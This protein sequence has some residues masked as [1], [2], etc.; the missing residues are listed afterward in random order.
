M[1]AVNGA[2]IVTEATVRRGPRGPLGGPFM[3]PPLLSVGLPSV[4]LTG[5]RG[6]DGFAWPPSFGWGNRFHAAKKTER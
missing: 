5:L 4:V 1:T 3:G 6:R 2:I